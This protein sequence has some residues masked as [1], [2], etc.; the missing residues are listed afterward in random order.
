MNLDIVTKR[1]KIIS[2]LQEEL[3]GVK[4]AYQESLENDPAY[5]ELQEE[6]SKFRESSKDKKIQVVSSQTM[7]AMADQMKELK[8]EITENKDILGQ[9]L[10]DY[11]KES[12]SM[13]ITDE[14][15]NVKRIVFSVKLING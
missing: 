12:G 8:T 4:A 7:K 14:D 15:G 6:A 3:N 9:E 1:L 11:Y 2:D 13:E 5:Q 10:A